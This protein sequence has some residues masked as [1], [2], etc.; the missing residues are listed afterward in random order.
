V[1]IVHGTVTNRIGKEGN[2]TYTLPDS[3]GF[4]TTELIAVQRLARNIYESRKNFTEMCEALEE[5]FAHYD[6]KK[7][8][9]AA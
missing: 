7:V 6:A 4:D 3:F 9:K 2:M 1:E 5:L 8:S